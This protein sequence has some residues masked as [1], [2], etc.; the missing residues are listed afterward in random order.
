[1]KWLLTSRQF[2]ATGWWRVAA[3]G[4]CA[5]SHRSKN[6]IW[7]E[8]GYRDS[9]VH[10]MSHQST[11]NRHD[12]FALRC[13]SPGCHHVVS[14]AFP[15]PCRGF[16]TA[17]AGL[18]AASPPCKSGVANAACAMR[19]SK[20]LRPAVSRSTAPSGVGFPVGPPVDNA[21]QIAWSYWDKGFEQLPD[22][23]RL[24]VETW[25]A[26]NPGWEIRL[27][28]RTSV[29]QFLTPKDLPRL[30]S[31]MYVPWQADAVRLALLAR[32]GGLWI[33]ASTICLQPFDRWIYG[34]IMSDKRPEDL[35]AFYFA[36]WG[37][38]MHK[39][40]DYVEN[41]VMAARRD[42]PLVVAWQALFNGYWDSKTRADAMCILLDP[43]G[44]PEHPLFRGV[45]LGHLKRFGQDLRNYLLMHAAFKK[46]IDQYPE[47]RRIWQEE[48]LLLRAEDTAFWHMEEPDVRW[49]VD[50]AMRK[51]LGQ[52][53]GPWLEHVLRSCPVLKFT[54]DTA[55]LLDEVPRVRLLRRSTC[56]G[57]AFNAVL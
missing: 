44:V 50:A 48:M 3:I 42:H 21:P 37:S 27:L 55:V 29:F 9:R 31:E 1:M 12:L 2:A 23:R 11:V 25:A 10:T 52:S 24:C 41:W 47:M 8:V 5:W 6:L 20:P 33:D 49:D 56:L 51:W 18:A 34:A 26:Q 57:D 35:G 39:S 28:D 32:Y 46:L 16:P 22:F 14:A 17:N 36:A 4:M 40:R 45:D 15:G 43:P 53:D 19:A 30:W 38:E 54:R 13:S 7:A